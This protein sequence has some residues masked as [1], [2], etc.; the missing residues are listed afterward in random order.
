M[1]EAHSICGGTVEAEFERTRAL[2]RMRCAFVCPFLA[3][4]CNT[5]TSLSLFNLHRLG[6]FIALLPGGGVWLFPCHCKSFVLLLFLPSDAIISFGSRFAQCKCPYSALP[7]IL[8]PVLD[9]RRIVASRLTPR[10]IVGG[11]H[12]CSALDEQSRLVSSQPPSPRSVAHPLL[13]ESLQH[14]IPEPIV[15]PTSLYRPQRHADISFREDQEH[16]APREFRIN[17]FRQTTHPYDANVL[18]SRPPW[19]FTSPNLDHIPYVEVDP[20]PLCARAD[21]RFGFEDYIVWPQS[22]S[23]AYP[24]APCVLRKPGP[25]EILEHSLWVLWEDLA[26]CDCVA[27]PGASWQK[28]GVLR[29]HFHT[30]LRREA[31]IITSR[32]LDATRRQALPSYVVLAVNALNA[33]L[34]RLQDLPMSFRDLT[35]QLTQ[36]Q[37]LCLDLLAM[38]AYHGHLFGRMMQRDRV[39]PLRKEL[40]GCFTNNPTTVENMFYAGIPVVYVRPSRLTLPSQVRV[41]HVVNN[42]AAIPSSIVTDPWPGTPCKILHDGAS[43]TRR[44]QMSRPCGRY[45]EDLV[46]LPDAQEEPPDLGPFHSSDPPV[47][48]TSSLPLSVQNDDQPAGEYSDSGRSPSPHHSI[49]GSPPPAIQ[50][51]RKDRRT[52]GYGGV[53]KQERQPNSRKAKKLQKSMWTCCSS[54]GKLLTR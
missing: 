20:T 9:A 37:R 48:T 41:R 7:Q 35:L 4:H 1:R 25:S 29:D 27:P 51:S 13:P 47:P 2:T 10:R 53:S 54:V 6:L 49:A 28:T 43:G 45:F 3:S 38:E 34:A 52:I 21:G 30:L 16:D 11:L 22:Y 17:S 31:N 19:V 18:L 15:S 12:S 33:T 42:F 46:P 40:I 39:F 5:F 36:A 8:L 26:R 23:E 14:V 32:A 50:R 24:W 44:L